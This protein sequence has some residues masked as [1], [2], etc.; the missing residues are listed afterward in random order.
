MLRLL[1][2]I[3][4]GNLA[5]TNETF[6]E[7]ENIALIGNTVYLQ[8]GDLLLTAIQNSSSIGIITSQRAGSTNTEKVPA[9][10]R[11][12]QK[13]L[14]TQSLIGKKFFSYLFNNNL[15]FVPSPGVQKK[16]GNLSRVGSYIMSL[17]F[18]D[19]LPLRNL[20]NPIQMNFQVVHNLS[21]TGSSRCSFWNE[22]KF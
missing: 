2:M 19:T 10:I 9:Q 20:E 15:F 14:I 18:L 4:E 11:V 5:N 16:S 8:G 17:T 21:N 3:A 6:Y 7:G 13:T 22:S 12:S 1:N